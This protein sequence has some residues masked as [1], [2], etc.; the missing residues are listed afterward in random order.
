[1]KRIYVLFEEFQK[2]GEGT[3]V[4]RK[5]PRDV[6]DSASSKKTKIDKLA[7]VRGDIEY[8]KC[9]KTKL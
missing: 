1:M 2:K 9:V 3:L 4:D 5:L 7:V 6:S 8:F